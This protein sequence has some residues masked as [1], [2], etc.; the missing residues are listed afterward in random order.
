MKGRV[1]AALG[2]RRDLIGVMAGVLW[3]ILGAHQL[4]L[5]RLGV[6]WERGR[7]K[8]KSPFSSVFPKGV[9]EG[10]SSLV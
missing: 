10:I 5:D 1:E 8:E 4:L 6:C 3:G 9:G 7:S 2:G